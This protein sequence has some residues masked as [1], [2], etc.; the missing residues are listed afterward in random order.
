MGSVAARLKELEAKWR[1]KKS[2][3]NGPVKAL[4]SM[5]A[6]PAEIAHLY[7]GPMKRSPRL[8]GGDVVQ[9]LLRLAVEWKDPRFI[10]AIKALFEHGI[11]DKDKQY[12][13]SSKH[14]PHGDDLKQQINSLKQRKDAVT[15]DKVLALRSDGMS[16]RLACATI[17]AETGR[18][19][20]SFVAAIE[21]VRHLIRC[22]ARKAASRL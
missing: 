2:S 9:E 19:A 3:R 17:A 20:A 5:I 8:R 13:F 18:Q 10:G 12:R 22:K 6:I 21:Q 11:V 4:V 14:G 7:R 1:C 16:E 15:I